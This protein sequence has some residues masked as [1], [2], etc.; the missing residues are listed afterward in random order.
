[1]G[2]CGIVLLTMLPFTPLAPALG[3]AALPSTFFAWLLLIVLCYMLLATVIKNL[4][5][6]KYGE[7]L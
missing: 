4:Y 5:I 6:K 2:G 1:M 3:L 7:L